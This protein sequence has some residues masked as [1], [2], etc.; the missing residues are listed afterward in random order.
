MK[1]RYSSRA[2]RDLAS[3]YQYLN[4]RSPA[5]AVNVLAA[6]YASIEFIRR[7]P[8]GAPKTS[9][10]GVHSKTVRK[11]RFKVFDRVIGS[12]PVVE[13]VHIRH[14]SRKTWLE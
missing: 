5:G 10:P 4:D 11:Y 2:T 3:I 13:I 8:L 7:R 9:I 12:D 6:I 14:T 1:V